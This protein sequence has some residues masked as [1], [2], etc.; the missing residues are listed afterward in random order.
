M[1]N[2]PTG[3]MSLGLALQILCDAHTRDD[4]KVGFALELSPRLDYQPFTREEYVRAWKTVRFAAGYITDPP[5]TPP[6]PR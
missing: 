2:E 5:H 6:A 1:I 3:Q 4:P